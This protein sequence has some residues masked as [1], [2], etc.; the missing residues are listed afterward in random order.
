MTEHGLVIDTYEQT[1]RV[2]VKKSGDCGGC[3]ACSIGRDRTMI[4]EVDNSINA[5][6]GDAVLVEVSD[7][8]AIRAG[9]LVLGLPLVALLIGVFG[10]SRILQSLVFTSSSDA[11]GGAIGFI[12]FALASAGVYFYS[13]HLKKKGRYSLKIVRILKT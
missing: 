9:L 8:Q 12:F 5:K 3:N 6:K 2:K 1:A 11:I 4:A 13:G 7:K 10:I